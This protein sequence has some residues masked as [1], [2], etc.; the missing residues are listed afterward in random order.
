MR[1]IR[2][3][4]D[5]GVR[6]GTGE[7]LLSR[8]ARLGPDEAYRITPGSRCE[9]ISHGLFGFTFGGFLKEKRRPVWLAS[10]GDGHLLVPSAGAA[11]YYRT[12]AIDEVTQIDQLKDV[13]E[14]AQDDKMRAEARKG[15]SEQSTIT[16]KALGL[17]IAV[18]GAALA[19]Q[20]LMIAIP[21]IRHLL[22]GASS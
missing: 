19:V 11:S 2:F 21:G 8:V 1:V 13:D 6:I 7:V 15:N 3:T 9:E 14:R 16:T 22:Q 20:L 17:T 10:K 18:L 12:P 4:V 5:E